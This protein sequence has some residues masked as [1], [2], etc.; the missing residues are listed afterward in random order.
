[1]RMVKSMVSE[2]EK[3]TSS[4]LVLAGALI[5]AAFSSSPT[6]QGRPRKCS[7]SLKHLRPFTLKRRRRSLTADLETFDCFKVFAQPKPEPLTSFPGIKASAAATEE[8]PKAVGE[9]TAAHT[10]PG[11]VT[12]N[13][14][15]GHSWWLQISADHLTSIVYA[16]SGSPRAA[17]KSSKTKH[18]LFPSHKAQ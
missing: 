1:M 13:C 5:F 11:S 8:L 4:P 15:S 10:S 17:G 2:E 16:P 12:L 6:T 7:Q 9:Q 14:C 18:R 3:M